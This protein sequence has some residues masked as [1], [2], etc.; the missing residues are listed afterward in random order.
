MS[1]AGLLLL[2]VSAALAVLEAHVPTHGA[3]GAAAVAALA[4]GLAL[5]FAGAGVSTRSR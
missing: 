1:E 5:V 3:I 2:F 4:A